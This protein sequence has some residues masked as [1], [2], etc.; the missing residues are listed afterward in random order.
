MIGI[1]SPVPSNF[2]GDD[3]AGCLPLCVK[4][5]PHFPVIRTARPGNWQLAGDQNTNPTEVKARDDYLEGCSATAQADAMRESRVNIE[6][7]MARSADARIPQ[8]ML[9][10]TDVAAP[11]TTAVRA[12]QGVSI[13]YF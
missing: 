4:T 7:M 12:P 1:P 8:R 11:T 2:R 6:T 3:E 9:N 13:E 10:T 5:L